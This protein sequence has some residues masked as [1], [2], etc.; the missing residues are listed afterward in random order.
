MPKECERGGVASDA[1]E[2]LD[3][4]RPPPANRIEQLAAAMMPVT[5]MAKLVACVEVGLGRAADIVTRH[6]QIKRFTLHH[7]KRLASIES[8]L[9]VKA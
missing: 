1:S 8:E 9:G 4:R 6:L 3:D 2:P 7:R 5:R